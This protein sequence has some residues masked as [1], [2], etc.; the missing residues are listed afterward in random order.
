MRV[1][2]LI[3]TTIIAGI[4][5]SSAEAST[6]TNELIRLN[7]NES[8][9]NPWATKNESD[10]KSKKKSKV[11][12]TSGF[13]HEEEKKQ[14]KLNRKKKCFDDLDKISFSEF[15]NVNILPIEIGGKVNTTPSVFD[16]KV[17][18]E[19]AFVTV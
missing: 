13:L 15:T 3:A 14:S 2:K 5:S 18:P 6:I 8:S 16:V 9:L 10:S 7:L 12:E 4:I 11:K 1:R 17:L 19:S